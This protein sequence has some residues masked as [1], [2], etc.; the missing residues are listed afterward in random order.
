MIGFIAPFMLILWCGDHTVTIPQANAAICQ[1]NG[2][3]LTR[4]LPLGENWDGYHC[5]PTGY[6][7]P[8]KQGNKQ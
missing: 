7:E 8:I 6:P 5:V 3:H 1:E 4:E 2:H